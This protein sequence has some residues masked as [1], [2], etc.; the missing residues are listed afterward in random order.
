[1]SISSDDDTDSSQK[2]DG[3]YDSEHDSHVDM[4]VEDVA[5]VLHGVDLDSDVNIERDRDNDE[6]EDEEE[7]DEEKEDEQEVEE[8]DEQEEEEKDEDDGKEPRTIGQ[9]E[10][11]HTSA[12]DA[13]TMVD[14]EPTVLPQ[15]G[16]EIRKLTPWPNLRHLPHRHKSLSIPHHHDL[17]RPILSVRCTFWGL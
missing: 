7:E 9:G 1:M 2:L 12:D 11:V 17:Q 8:E 6:E 5:D 15:Q 13:N 3:E 4:H 16:Q 14:N 10:M